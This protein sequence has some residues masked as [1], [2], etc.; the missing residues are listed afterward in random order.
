L[1][2]N[3]PIG[4]RNGDLPQNEGQSNAVSRR[5]IRRDPFMM[6]QP[7]CVSGARAPGR[8]RDFSGRAGWERRI[9]GRRRSRLRNKIWRVWDGAPSRSRAAGAD[10][11][12]GSNFCRENIARGK[13]PVRA[14]RCDRRVGACD[15]KDVQLA[16]RQGARRRDKKERGPPASK[17]IPLGQHD[18]APGPFYAGPSFVIDIRRCREE[19]EGPHVQLSFAPPRSSPAVKRFLLCRLRW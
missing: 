17:M 11:G 8:N 16:G 10:P 14:P 13:L 15:Q 12:R 9:R 2:K 18:N 5:S 6:I 1:F 3:R 4:L 19:N 7:Q